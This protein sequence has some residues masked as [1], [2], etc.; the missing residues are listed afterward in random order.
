MKLEVICLCTGTKYP[1]RYADIL[2]AMAKRNLTVP[3]EFYCYTDDPKG[4]KCKTRKI[5]AGMAGWWNK[6]RFFAPG[7]LK[8]KTLY[9]DL[10][11]TINGSLDELVALEGFHI[12][13]DWYYDC[14]NSSVMLF[15]PADDVSIVWKNFTAKMMKKY[16]GDQDVITE[17]L[18]DAKH[19]PL[20][21]CLSYKK[22]CQAGVQKGTKIVVFHGRPNP[23][24]FPSPWIRG[25]WRE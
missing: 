20:D 5:P 9:L 22:F 19:F 21:W 3:F 7:F 13:Q 1:K 25:V 15:D 16:I 4:F 6:L 18:P 10:D 14:H 11:V 12:T 24:E 17:L 23:H 8:T 2:H